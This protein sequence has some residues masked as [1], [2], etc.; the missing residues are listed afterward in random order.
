MR[1]RL[2]SL[3]KPCRNVTHRGSLDLF[4]AK[5]AQLGSCWLSSLP[6]PSLYPLCSACCYLPFW[7]SSLDWQKIYIVSNNHIL[8]HI[9]VWNNF[10][11]TTRGVRLIPLRVSPASALC[12]SIY[13]ACFFFIIFFSHV[14][15]VFN[16]MYSQRAMSGCR[17]LAKW[18]HRNR[19]D[20]KRSKSCCGN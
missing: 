16:E 3:I 11:W 4:N 7:L 20:V 13:F 10:P 1:P 14:C 6:L 8:T 19:S 17:S 5:H 9:T 2:S 18:S 12:G 15:F